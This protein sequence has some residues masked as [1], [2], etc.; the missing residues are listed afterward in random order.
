M[1]SGRVGLIFLALA[2]IASLAPAQVFWTVYPDPVPLEQPVLLTIDNQTRSSI[3]LTSSAPWAIY[4]LN[5]KLV[6][7]PVG[8][9]VVLNIPPLGNKQWT[10]DQKGSGTGQVPSGIYE[11]RITYSDGSGAKTLKTPFQIDQVTF[12]V[13]GKAT[14]GG[15][16]QLDM[17][18]PTS[19]GT[20]YQMA[21]SLGNTP[22]LPLPVTRLLALNPDALFW[23][24][25]LQPAPIFQNFSG[26]TSKSGY[27]TGYV[28]IPAAKP[29][30]GVTFYAAGA[31]VV[32]AA[33][34]GIHVHSAS[35]AIQI[36]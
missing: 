17:H 26:I 16:V 34:G 6:F 19:T 21:C 23:M 11:A 10:W 30:I 32:A 9:P 36:Q 22:G 31:T 29:L 27:A 14:P 25:I 15:R 2:A 33:P 4:D 5:Q 12:A 35:K 28:N 18:T 8:L 3:M 24:S 13:S 20:T 7:G 1:T